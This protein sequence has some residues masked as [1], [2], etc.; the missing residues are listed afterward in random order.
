M[1]YKKKLTPNYA[2]IR[3]PNTS[4]ASKHT[5]HTISKIRIKEEIEYL[6]IKKKLNQQS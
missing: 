1:S 6:Y 3:I 4:T 2:R 5:Q